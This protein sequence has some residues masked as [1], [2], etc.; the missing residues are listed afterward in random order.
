V[1]LWLQKETCSYLEYIYIYSLTARLILLYCLVRAWKP[2]RVVLL[3]DG[4]GR[5]AELMLCV[6]GGERLTFSNL[7]DFRAAFALPARSE[8]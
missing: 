4:V 2:G 8:S 5:L 1:K 6:L 3:K 7:V